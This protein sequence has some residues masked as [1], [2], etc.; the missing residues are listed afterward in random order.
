MSQKSEALDL[1]LVLDDMIGDLRRRLVGWEVM[2]TLLHVQRRGGSDATREELDDL[3]RI[4]RTALA[5]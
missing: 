5:K 3:M 2:R 1:E 4:I